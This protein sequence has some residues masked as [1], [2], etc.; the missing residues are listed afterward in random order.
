MSKI[1]VIGGKGTALCIGEQ[2]AHAQRDFNAPDEFLGWALDEPAPGA[3]INGY[4]ILCKPRELATQFPARDV[5]FIFALYKPEQMR[6]RTLL[7]ASYQIPPER[8]ATFVH[9]SAVVLP[10]ARIGSG[11]VVLSHC[12]LHANVTLGAH[13][14]VNPNVVIEHDTQVGDNAF[15]AAHACLGSAVRI[16]CGVFIG[17]NSA[18]R[19]QVAIGD[20]AFVGMGANVLHNIDSDALA[21]GNPAKM[22]A[23]KQHP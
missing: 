16:G 12:T 1:I 20:F 3:S 7:L 23:R 11:T 14:I 15:I 5:K 10:S 13:V 22:R 8:F 2:I 6:A 18:V 19:E 21:Y 4:P 17:L 9:P